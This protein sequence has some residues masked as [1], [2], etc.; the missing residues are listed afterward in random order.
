MAL[1]YKKSIGETGKIAIWRMEEREDFFLMDLELSLK[2]KVRLQNLKGNRR[3]EW[4]TSR[5]LLH[6]MTGGG[7]RIDCLVDE[8]GKPYLSGHQL[9]LSI[10]HSRELVG[11]IVDEAQNV[12]IDL[13]K[14]VAKIERI[15]HKFMRPTETKSLRKATKI[16]HLHIY[17]CAKE[18]LYKAYGRKELDYKEHILVKPFSYE[19]RGNTTAVVKK[20]EFKA[21]FDVHFEKLGNFMFVYV[22]EISKHSN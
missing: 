2:E 21:E 12:G 11:V 9:E 20:G 22:V 3:R 14:I 18:A 13:Q 5:W 17:W 10:T 6:Q 7:E 15:A 19:E 16:E 4:V 1:F 8:F